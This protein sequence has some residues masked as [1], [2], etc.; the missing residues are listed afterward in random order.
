M[1]SSLEVAMVLG[2][3]PRY[4]LD[5]L[6]NKPCSLAIIDK[7]VDPTLRFVLSEDSPGY[8]NTQAIYK[9]DKNVIYELGAAYRFYSGRVKDATEFAS[10]IEKEAKS[11]TQSCDSA[12]K[13]FNAM[14]ETSG[15]Q[16]VA[17]ELLY[18]YPERLFLAKMYIDS[19]MKDNPQQLFMY[20]NGNFNLLDLNVK[21]KT[22]SFIRYADGRR[23]KTYDAMKTEVIKGVYADLLK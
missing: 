2:A 21:S 1:I 7:D 18:A 22:L 14:A 15:R 9:L 8:F 17:K 4:T 6:N 10:F 12:L 11:K 3:N 5:I 13:Q 16:Q 19:W 20:A 23:F